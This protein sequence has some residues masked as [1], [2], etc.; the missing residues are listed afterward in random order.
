M[1][2]VTRDDVDGRAS[3]GE[4]TD[5][6]VRFPPW[7]PHVLLPRHDRRSARDGISLA[8]ASSRRA[9][10]VQR[11]AYTAA[12][13]GGA[14]VLP[15]PRTRWQPPMGTDGFAS[16]RCDWAAAGLGFDGW[17]VYERPQA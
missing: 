3:D 7:R 4:R 2:L 9:R 5:E 16:V 12:L 8:T 11:L 15:G 1:A 13:A 14:R 10:A 6:Y 17:S